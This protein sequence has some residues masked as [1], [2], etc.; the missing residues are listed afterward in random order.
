[1]SHGLVEHGEDS[2]ASGEIPIE[3]VPSEIEWD[4]EF[5]RDLCLCGGFLW[6][7]TWYRVYESRLK[8][9]EGLKR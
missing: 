1:M 2:D 6:W 3:I 8:R 7:W 4:F 9:F 5:V